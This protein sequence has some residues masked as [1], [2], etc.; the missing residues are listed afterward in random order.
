MAKVFE[1]I[2]SENLTDM[3]SICLEYVENRAEKIF[4][5]ASAEGH[6]VMVNCFMQIHGHILGMGNLNKA[7][8][9]GEKPFETSPKV[10]DQVITI[11]FKDFDKIKKACKEYEREVP[12]EIKATY[13]CRTK[14]F[15]CKLGYDNVWSVRRNTDSVTIWREWQAEEQRKLDL[16]LSQ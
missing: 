7:L 9:P 14:Q 8:K 15:D 3:V 11:L 4:V 2:L 10:Q 1:D 13:D 5:Y 12:K 16:G 6:S